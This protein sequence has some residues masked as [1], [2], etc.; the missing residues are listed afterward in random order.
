MQKYDIRFKQDNKVKQP[1]KAKISQNFSY[2]EYSDNDD[3]EYDVSHI[4]HLY[5]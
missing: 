5:K 1:K 2:C 3:D 4:L